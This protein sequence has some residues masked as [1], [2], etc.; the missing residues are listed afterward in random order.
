MTE[1]SEI[2]VLRAEHDRRVTELLEANNREVERR[3]KAEREHSL[4]IEVLR[5][6]AEL[7]LTALQAQ[8]RAQMFLKEPFQGHP[9]GNEG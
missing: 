2:E 1:K 9:Q 5:E 8:Q 6:I 7:K 3:R 4:A